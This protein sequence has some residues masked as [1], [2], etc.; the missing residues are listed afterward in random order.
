MTIYGT[1]PGGVPLACINDFPCNECC[2]T[3]NDGY[4]KLTE[5]CASDVGTCPQNDDNKCAACNSP[6]ASD[7]EILFVPKKEWEQ[8]HGSST[9]LF[10]K[11]DNCYQVNLSNTDSP[12]STDAAT[13]FENSG[14]TTCNDCCC[15]PISGNPCNIPSNGC[16]TSISVTLPS[17]GLGAGEPDYNF[18]G[19]CVNTE[20]CPDPVD[21]ESGDGC[22]QLTSTNSCPCTPPV[23]SA[24]FV[25]QWDGFGYAASVGSTGFLGDTYTQ[26]PSIDLA[27]CGGTNCEDAPLSPCCGG[28]VW[29]AG[30]FAQCGGDHQLGWRSFYIICGFGCEFWSGD[31]TQ[32]GANV[33]SF[34]G[35]AGY[36]NLFSNG[37]AFC[38]LWGGSV[39]IEAVN[40]S[41]DGYSDAA[42]CAGSYS[43]EIN[44]VGQ[45]SFSACQPQTVSGSVTIS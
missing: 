21:G 29:E 34:A 7:P 38:G 16:P 30:V 18:P 25:A 13:S 15:E 8:Q 33:A 31:G 42:N 35:E 11:G 19:R 32:N 39:K 10:R 1:N 9:N 27:R 26:T 17:L 14:T 41:D 28:I 22:G 40:C 36:G 4:V 6:G 12:G 44:N 23:P 37:G 20:D 2:C 24:T 45:T 5:C 43:Y 3:D